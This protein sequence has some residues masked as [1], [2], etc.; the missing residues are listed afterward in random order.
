MARSR[1]ILQTYWLP[2]ISIGS[3]TSRIA[4]SG[5]EEAKQKFR[6]NHVMFPKQ[7]NCL[8]A[9]WLAGMSPAW[10]WA[11]CGAGRTRQERGSRL[12]VVVGC[13]F[14]NATA[15]GSTKGRQDA[16][17]SCNILALLRFQP[18]RG[19]D[20]FAAR[21]TTP[22]FLFCNFNPFLPTASL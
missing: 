7:L 4:C 10:C 21:L 22:A 19:H 1:L 14:P 12:V 8:H 16:H 5:S 11:N 6:N 9:H 15:P 20:A 13:A 17:R 3:E 2:K 18:T